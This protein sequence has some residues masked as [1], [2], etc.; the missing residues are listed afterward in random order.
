M[1]TEIERKFLVRGD[2]WRAGAPGVLCRQG[3]LMSQAD[4]SLR[5]R[6][7][8]DGG[9]LTIK[10]P[11]QGLARPEY[12]YPIPVRDAEELLD[13]FCPAL[14]IEKRR[15]L[16][17]YGGHTWEVDE[18]LGAN[19]GLVLAEVELERCDEAVLLPDW[20][21]AEVSGDR[22]YL[23]ASLAQRPYAQWNRLATAP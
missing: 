1:G 8:G 10:G 4:C 2:G 3:Y 14:R 17:E 19:L 23:N 13:R 9:Y 12:E 22:R 5:V 6:V 7:L 11:A 16:R 20:V 21:G 18:F 15:H